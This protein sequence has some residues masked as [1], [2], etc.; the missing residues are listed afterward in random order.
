M[1]ATAMRLGLDPNP[2]KAPRFWEGEGV[3]EA[4]LLDFISEHGTRA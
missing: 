2:K 4:A 3:I 1:A